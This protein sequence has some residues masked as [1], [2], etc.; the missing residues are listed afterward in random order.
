MCVQVVFRAELVCD[1]DACEVLTPVT[2]DRVDVEEYDQSGEQ[3]Q[4]DQQEDADLDPLSVHI[5]APKAGNN[6]KK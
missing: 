1:R 3:T 5:R 2:F 6:K 4:E